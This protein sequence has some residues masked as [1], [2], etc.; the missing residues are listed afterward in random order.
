MFDESWGL[1]PPEGVPS[2]VGSPLSGFNSLI[3]ILQAGLLP[4]LWLGILAASGALIIHFLLPGFGLLFK[5]CL[6]YGLGLSIFSFMLGILSPLGLPVNRASALWVTGAGLVLGLF[7]W[8]LLSRRKNEESGMRPSSQK[9]R[10]FADIWLIGFLLLALISLLIGVGK[11]YHATDEI[12]LWGAKGYGIA[13]MESLR[14]IIQWGTNTVP[15]PL[16]VPILIASAKLLFGE[17]LPASKM[18]FSGYYLALML[19]IYQCLLDRGVRRVLAGFS[20]LLIGTLPIVFRHATIAYANLPMSFYFVGALLLLAWSLLEFQSRRAEQAALLSGM[21]FACA[22]WTRPEGLAMAWLTTAFVLAAH[23]LL[24]RNRVEI[25]FLIYLFAPLALYSLFWLVFKSS[26]YPVMPDRSDIAS[27]ALSQISR[28]D[29]H[30]NEAL[31][32]ISSTLKRPFDYQTWGALGLAIILIVGS[33]VLVRTPR[34]SGTL[35]LLSGI[36]LIGMTAGIYYLV[37]FDSVH[38]ISW[39]ISTGYDRM[40]LPGILLFLIGGILLSREFLD[41]RQ[42]GAVPLDPE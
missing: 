19:V 35:I 38:D 25:R 26:I 17:A 3:K 6:G 1:I 31:F 5:A 20:V 33:L 23:Y 37:S 39:W 18:V 22:A 27:E 10:G 41:D 12:M 9:G 28:G 16:Q 42:R 14:D 11:G 8:L 24:F 15:Y 4:L 30:I 21:L 7:T 32:V 13:A 34:Q 29:L 2:G 40:L 36:F